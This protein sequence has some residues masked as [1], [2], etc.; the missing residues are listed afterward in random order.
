MHASFAG[1]GFEV[2]VGDGHSAECG[3]FAEEHAEQNQD[4]RHAPRSRKKN[5][6]ADAA[7]LKKLDDVFDSTPLF[8]FEAISETLVAAYQK[9]LSAADVQAGIDFYTSEAGKRLLEKVP[10]DHSRGQRERRT[11]GAAEAGGV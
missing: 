7:T 11:T 2:D 9:N 3:C 5:P 4:L 8:G 10:V 6:D 1:T